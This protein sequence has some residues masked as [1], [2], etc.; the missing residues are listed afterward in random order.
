MPATTSTPDDTASK[1]IW[2]SQPLWLRSWSLADL[3]AHPKSN[4]AIWAFLGNHFVTLVTLLV[5]NL[6]FVIDI[7]LQLRERYPAMLL[8]TTEYDWAH[9][10]CALTIIASIIGFFVFTSKI[11]LYITQ[12]LVS[13][14]PKHTP[15]DY[16]DHICTTFL[17]SACFLILYGYSLATLYHL[18]SIKLIPICI[19]TIITGFFLFAIALSLWACSLLDIIYGLCGRGWTGQQVEMALRRRSQHGGA[20]ETELQEWRQVTNVGMGDFKSLFCGYRESLRAI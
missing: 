17:L 11:T 16:H 10:P 9:G 13:C 6:L 19:A 7:A 12:D 14:R 18:L 5:L 20:S 2:L 8:L 4:V 3:S 15:L 1:E